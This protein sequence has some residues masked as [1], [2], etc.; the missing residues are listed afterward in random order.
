MAPPHCRTLEEM[1]ALRHRPL[2]LAEEEEEPAATPPHH[3]YHHYYYQP[4]HG[5]GP[6][7]PTAVLPCAAV[8]TATCMPMV[9]VPPPPPPPPGSCCYFPYACPEWRALADWCRPCT[10]R[11]LFP[12]MPAVDEPRACAA[13]RPYTDQRWLRHH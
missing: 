2:P 12:D 11:R 8:S 4:Q 5:G 13:P 6:P 3:Y 7:Y 1:R 10:R 9:C